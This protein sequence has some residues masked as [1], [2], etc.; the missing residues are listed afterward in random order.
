MADRNRR[1][2]RRERPVEKQVEEE[3]AP[4]EV[5]E[6][7]PSR[8]HNKDNKERSR[9]HKKDRE[10]RSRRQ[11]TEEV[12]QQPEEEEVEPIER[13][14]VV[15]DEVEQSQAENRSDEQ[16]EEQ[17]DAKPSTSE[18]VEEDV[19][20]N[21]KKSTTIVYSDAIGKA[22]ERDLAVLKN[23]AKGAPK[24]QHIHGTKDFADI[25]LVDGDNNEHHLASIMLSSVI[26]RTLIADIMECREEKNGFC[27]LRLPIS[28]IATSILVR[29][30]Y[31]LPIHPDIA[32]LDL[33]TKKQIIKEFDTIQAIPL[34]SELYKDRELISIGD[35]KS[36]ATW[37]T[38]CS[39][40][41]VPL[42]HA[43]LPE[44]TSQI[45]V[46]LD[47]PT[48]QFVCRVLPSDEEVAVKLLWC[49]ARET[50][51]TDKSRSE[52]FNECQQ[53]LG[54]INPAAKL[55]GTEKLT[56]MLQEATNPVVYR[57]IL[58]KIINTK[59]PLKPGPV[60]IVPVEEKK[61]VG[62]IATPSKKLKSPGKLQ[63][64]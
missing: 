63:K 48:V 37:I 20:S 21:K 4:S 6:E 11:D 26:P 1:L 35:P 55:P 9:H 60:N 47:V 12:E 58:N 43:Q 28:N 32:K 5:V 42:S 10:S 30:A 22:S 7:R 39:T 19:K 13:S 64:P 56:N 45:L 18:D 27:V 53:L 38:T 50:T 41:G 59:L 31:Q 57:F 23:I 44:I 25:V 24:F 15:E 36:I 3:E 2:N 14:A 52:M 62:K 40:S 29:Y 8:K 51:S 16:Q 49:C 17:E 33:E 61:S 54:T 34:I 46:Y